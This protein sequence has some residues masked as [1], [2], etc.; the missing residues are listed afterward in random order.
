VPGRV[1]WCCC[2]ARYTAGC[3]WPAPATADATLCYASTRHTLPRR[4]ISAQRLARMQ[5]YAAT[6]TSMSPPRGNSTERKAHRASAANGD[7]PLV[8]HHPKPCRIAAMVPGRPTKE[9]LPSL[10]CHSPPASF[11]NQNSR[12]FFYP[13]IVGRSVPAL[14]HRH[15]PPQA[16]NGDHH[17][18]HVQR[19]YS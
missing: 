12:L 16:P 14:R 8:C 18:N 4:A 6:L 5:A 2:V 19:R 1:V 7:W 10:Q 17:R 11:L 3:D 13:F 15:R 9:L